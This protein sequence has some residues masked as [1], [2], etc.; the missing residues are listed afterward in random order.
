M[1]PLSYTV[2]LA[3]ANHTGTQAM[4]TISDAGALATLNSV[5]LTSEVTGDLP[6]V[7]IAQIST[8]RFLGRDTTG[9]GDIEQ[10]TGSQA[11][12]L[13]DQFSLGT[14]GVV[15]GLSSTPAG[16][17][18][19][20]D[21]GVWAAPAG[22]G[23]VN[24]S[25]TPV[26]N[27]LAIWTDATTIEGD[28]DLTFDGTNLNV[29]N[30]ITLGGTVDGRDIAADGTR[31]ANTSGTNTGD[32]TITLTGDVTGSGTGSFAATIA[33]N[34]VETGMILDSNV[35]LAKIED[36]A[37]NS[38]LGRD[39]TGT[40]VP[41]VLSAATARSVMD[42]DQAGTDNSTPV[43]FGTSVYDYATLAGQEITLAAIDLTTDVT[44]DLPVASVLGTLL[45]QPVPRIMR[46]QGTTRPQ[47]SCSRTVPPSLPMMEGSRA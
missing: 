36:I 27:Q 39:T 19:L 7:N 4:A 22:G 20:R 47:V 23:N 32:Q 30:N 5:D 6:F 9:T 10:L 1:T 29:G 3:R 21:D 31:L 24:A 41:E 37:T 16:N 2:V 25:P 46:S 28:A 26:N 43:T 35:T 15:P 13:L 38:I 8:D 45:D 17:N 42:V 40:G 44:G 18:F 33:V 14:Q 12:A 34:A 11:T